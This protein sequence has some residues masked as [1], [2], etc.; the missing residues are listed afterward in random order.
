M[1]QRDISTQE[2]HFCACRRAVKAISVWVLWRELPCWML[3][4]TYYSDGIE[5]FIVTY[6]HNGRACHSCHTLLPHTSVFVQVCVF[7]CVQCVLTWSNWL[8]MQCMNCNFCSVMYLE[9]CLYIYFKSAFL[10]L[11]RF[12]CLFV[13]F[14]LKKA[15]LE[16]CFMEEQKSRSSLAGEQGQHPA[17]LWEAAHRQRKDGAVLKS[18][19]KSSTVSLTQ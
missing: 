8:C 11:C 4:G 6:L 12:Y 7:I 3:K 18:L 16:G 15:E 13:C 5:S 9:W 19:L 17:A 10:Q 2:K 14:G 1:Q